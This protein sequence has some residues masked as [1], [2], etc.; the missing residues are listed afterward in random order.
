M[1]AP[2]EGDNSEVQRYLAPYFNCA[3][4]K[5]EQTKFVRLNEM[6]TSSVHGLVWYQIKKSAITVVK[7]TQES[8]K[9][10]GNIEA[11]CPR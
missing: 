6:F 10:I 4:A 2:T 1:G 5:R 3:H 8:H 7:K 11:P 9:I